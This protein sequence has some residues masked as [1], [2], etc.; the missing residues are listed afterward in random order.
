MEIRNTLLYKKTVY[1]D[2]YTVLEV[3]YAHSIT[4]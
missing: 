3:S 1:T 2:I 4:N